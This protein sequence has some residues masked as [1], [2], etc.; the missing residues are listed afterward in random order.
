MATSYSGTSGS[1]VYNG[2]AGT[3][4]G[5]ARNWNLTVEGEVLDTS[6]FGVGWRGH[7]EGIK[8]WE[9][10]IEAVTNDSDT[11]QDNLWD[12]LVDGA[13][14]EL[15]LY[16]G[17]AAGRRGTAIIHQSEDTQSFDGFGESTWSFT[18]DGPL[19]RI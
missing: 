2:T 17:T 11:Q 8:M 1:V 16:M 13:K 5:G 3:A 10:S 19:V 15:V 12:R 18:G 7:D 4:V 6:A 9:G 14:V